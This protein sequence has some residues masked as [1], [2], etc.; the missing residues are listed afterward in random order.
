MP[1]DYDELE[2]LEFI[3]APTESP[4]RRSLFDIDES[5]LRE[6]KT[7]NR[8]FELP[9]E[10]TPFVEDILQKDEKSIIEYRPL[11]EIRYPDTDKRRI[12]PRRTPE[13]RKP[14]VGYPLIRLSE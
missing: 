5:E 6:L 12:P 11:L 8:K 13:K 14:V 10:L 2:T 7:L 3:S 1:E 4:R 9:P